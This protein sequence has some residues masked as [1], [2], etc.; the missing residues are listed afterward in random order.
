MLSWHALGDD[1]RALGAN[2]AH[3]KSLLG[4]MKLN[5]IE[6][7]VVSYGSQPASILPGAAGSFIA[8]VVRANLSMAG[9]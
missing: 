6:L 1:G 4:V 2:A 3:S 8:S 5:E 9:R 7:A